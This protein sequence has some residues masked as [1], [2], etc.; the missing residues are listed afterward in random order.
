[1]EAKQ[2]MKLSMKR[3]TGDLDRV[4]A[5]VR[6]VERDLEFVGRSPAEHGRIARM[7]EQLGEVHAR[8][9]GVR[10]FVQACERQAIQEP[11]E[12]DIDLW[13]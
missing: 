11:E 12:Q 9:D 8:L 10:E 2:R 3:L 7:R 1:M 4:G 13:L 5:L 6:S